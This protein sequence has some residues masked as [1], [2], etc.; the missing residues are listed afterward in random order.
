M[1]GINDILRAQ[2]P[3]TVANVAASKS[4]A[5]LA[6]LVAALRWPD[7]TVPLAFVQG[8]KVIGDIEPSHIFR[9]LPAKK[10]ADAPEDLFGQVAV[11]KFTEL[12]S[13]RPGPDA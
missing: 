12:L 10:V 11:S 13:S 5:L 1:K 4:P 2:M 3:Y 6:L 8:F 9:N 7:R